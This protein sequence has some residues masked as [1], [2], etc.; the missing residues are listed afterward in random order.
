MQ[1]LITADKYFSFVVKCIGVFAI[2]FQLP[3]I[4]L[5]INRIKPIPPRKMRKAR[6][7]V[8]IGGFALGILLPF[9]YDPITQ[10][11]MALPIIV[12][13]ELSIV[14]VSLTNRSRARK[15]PKF[16]SI[17]KNISK[18]LVPIFKNGLETIDYLNVGVVEKTQ[19]QSLSILENKH[20]TN[21]KQS[22]NMPD[23]KLHSR[24]TISRRPII[25]DIMSVN[26]KPVRSFG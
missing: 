21:N 26:K 22:R 25:M 8:V 11:L 3:L 2:I 6:K 23:S 20:P 5:F 4:I 16:D 12:M 14:L 15:Y 19:K 24:A 10:T 13:Y 1:S 7:W 18:P 17:A 9:A